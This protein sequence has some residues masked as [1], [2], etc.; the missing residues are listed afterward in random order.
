MKYLLAL[1]I[2]GSAVFSSTLVVAD[3]NVSSDITM[4]RPASGERNFYVGAS[5]GNASYDDADD[6]DISFDLFLGLDLN[7]VLSVELGWANF[8]EAEETGSIEVT[9]L[10][11]A[12]IGHLALQNNLSV[13]GKL[14]ISSWDADSTMGSVSENDSDTD[15]F[16]GLG[17]DY[18]ISGKTFVRFGVDQYAIDEE[19][20]TVYSVGIKQRF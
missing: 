6:S 14:G 15:V 11:A 17:A 19:D 3:S 12:M 10:H 1:I 20:I 18:Q 4:S 9:A 8:G 7:E 5:I 16:F 2:A 13:Y